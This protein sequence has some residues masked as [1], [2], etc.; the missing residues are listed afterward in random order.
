M[1]PIAFDTE[2]HPLGMR[3]HP[4]SDKHDKA[5]SNAI[6]RLIVLS[7]AYENDQGE[8]ETKLLPPE[9]AAE[10]WLSRFTEDDTCLIGH[11][12]AF[13]TL[14]MARAC[15]DFLDEEQVD[16]ILDT[17]GPDTPLDEVLKTCDCMMH[18][19]DLQNPELVGA[20]RWGGG[21]PISD[22]M[23]RQKLIDNAL[24]LGTYGEERGISDRG[25]ALSRL[26]K[27]HLSRDRSE[28]KKGD[29]AWRLRYNE[30][31]DVPLEEWPK[32]ARKYA[33][34]DAE[35]TFRVWKSQCGKKTIEADSQQH[36]IVNKHMVRN[37]PFQVASSIHLELLSARGFEVN[38]RKVLDLRQ[39]F[40][41]RKKDLESKMERMGLHDGSSKNLDVIR[42]EMK[43]SWKKTFGLND[44]PPKT[45]TGKVSYA[46]ENRG[47]LRR[48]GCD[49]Q[50]M[51]VLAE[52]DS[53]V[54]N[55]G[56]LK[57]LEAAYPY[58]IHP[59]YNAMVA[60]G[61]TS[62]FG[63]NIQNTPAHGSGRAPE[64]RECFRSREGYVFAIADYSSL[65]LATLAQA[66]INL[67]IES[68]LADVI[69]SG[70]DCHLLIAAQLVEGVSGYEEA[71][72]AYNDKSHRLHSEVKDARSLAKVV[73]YGF[74]GGM[75]PST[76][77]N[78][79]APSRGHDDITVQQARDLRELWF[80]T[81][82]GVE[83]YIGSYEKDSKIDQIAKCN[84]IQNG[85]SQEVWRMSQ[86]GP[87]GRTKN[88]SQI[89]E[90]GP[91]GQ[92]TGWRYRT[93]G[94]YCAARNTPFQGLGADGGKQA[95]NMLMRSCRRDSSAL[96]GGHPLAFVHDE[97]IV[98]VPREGAS[99]AAEELSYIMVEGMSRFIPNVKIEAEPELSSYW[100]KDAYP[101]RDEEGDLMV[102][103][104]DYN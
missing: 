62:S 86:H 61:R 33:L 74:P 26:E 59:G 92:T 87:V 6:P 101:K 67:G 73:N 50:W 66:C 44:T 4:Y 80:N 96:S 68:K 19:G 81:F 65:E 104:E 30:L 48:E 54:K 93:T 100:T 10:W 103:G 55:H 60:T 7:A 18:A 17:Q 37:E 5:V 53:A 20:C 22:T 13:D 47:K 69:N 76:F 99:E 84:D 40:V 34:E 24:T 95:L 16:D 79:H 72:E 71:V 88:W 90:D 85:E 45:S 3:D 43:S 29:D 98:E 94:S 9:K 49:D 28:D 31:V 51:E 70:K 58:S 41:Q 27:R 91:R 32:D 46:K 21:L 75:G 2:T 39:H 89:D 83:R 56:F 97:F 35:G 38:P 82:P 63:P 11:N 57:P 14:V 64:I 102:Y 36:L 23:Y 42:S 52:Y 25:Y 78:E 77:A 8:V 15:R 12:V 1:N